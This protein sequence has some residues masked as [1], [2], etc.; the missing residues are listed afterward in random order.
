LSLPNLGGGA[1]PVGVRA[2]GGPKSLAEEC[3]L[4]FDEEA[5]VE[6]VDKLK[7]VIKIKIDDPCDLR[8]FHNEREIAYFSIDC[9]DVPAYLYSTD[10]DP[11]YQHAGIGTAMLK[12]AHECF[13]QLRPPLFNPMETD[14]RMTS[15]GFAL[16]TKGQQL[17]YVLPFPD[18]T[19]GDDY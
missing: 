9:G 18:M 5:T 12:R 6:F 3:T 11:E 10:V 2:L 16:V 1:L 14:N 19:R 15:L 13:G 7:R 17:G 4:R 8:A